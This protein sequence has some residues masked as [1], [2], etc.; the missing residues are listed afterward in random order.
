MHSHHLASSFLIHWNGHDPMGVVMP[1]NIAAC[2]ECQA[3]VPHIPYASSETWD[4]NPLK[5]QKTM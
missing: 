4:S 3:R 5:I 2:C 1:E